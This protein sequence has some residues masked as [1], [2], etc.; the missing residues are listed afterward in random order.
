MYLSLLTKSSGKLDISFYA[1][2]LELIYEPRVGRN[3]ALLLS[4]FFNCFQAVKINSLDG[5]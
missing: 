4:R 1:V 3:L 5:V 2:V